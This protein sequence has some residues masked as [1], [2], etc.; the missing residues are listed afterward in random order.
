MII[1]SLLSLTSGFFSKE[2]LCGK[3]SNF[4]KQSIFIHEKN[5]IDSEYIPLVLKC[6]PIFVVFLGIFL[7]VHL[8]T[9]TT[10]SNT[11]GY[12]KRFNKV[13]LFLFNRYH[14]DT[15]YNKIAYKFL[16]NSY[17]LYKF[18][19]QKLIEITGPAFARLIFS[20]VMRL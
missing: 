13:H 7:G 14:I 11:E 18:V 3:D 9:I 17:I 8:T 2:I 19:D 16:F 20:V 1:L 5:L 15:L 6:L 4:F 10:L 12:Y